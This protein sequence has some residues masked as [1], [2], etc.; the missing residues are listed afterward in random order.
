MKIQGKL[1]RN[2]QGKEGSGDKNIL[3]SVQQTSRFSETEKNYFQ[4]LAKSKNQPI[5]EPVLVSGR[6]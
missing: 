3:K 1:Q 4:R 5:K 2:F 6:I